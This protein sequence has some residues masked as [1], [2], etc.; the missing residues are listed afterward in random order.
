MARADVAQNVMTSS[1]PPLSTQSRPDL[2]GVLKPL[3]PPVP[4]E[5]YLSPRARTTIPDTARRKALKD[6]WTRDWTGVQVPIVITGSGTPETGWEGKGV[7]ESLRIMA[8]LEPTPTTHPGERLARLPSF[9]HLPIRIQRIYPLKLKPSPVPQYAPPPPRA[10]RQNPKT[11]SN[12]RTLNGR[13]LRRAYQRL[14]TSLPWVTP[15]NRENENESGQWRTCT[16]EEMVDPSLLD[17]R[18]TKGKKK[19]L[20]MQKA[21][22]PRVAES[23]ES[24]L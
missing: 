18:Q 14:W 11:W 24:L 1:N 8:Q 5:V 17:S 3:A 10:T 23:E 22:W 12:P 21:K 6:T 13:K 15:V 16:Y 19:E 9:D 2:P 4:G 7:I 20:H